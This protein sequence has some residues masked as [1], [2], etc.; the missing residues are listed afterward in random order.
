[1]KRLDTN[2]QLKDMVSVIMPCYN[3]QAF[4]GEAIA[5]VVGQTWDNWELI[6]IDDG[7]QD[8]SVHILQK[9][10]DKDS[11]IVALA[12]EENMGVSKTRNKGINLA[13]GQWIAFLDSD[14]VWK[15]D[16]L[17]RQMLL[18]QEKQ[19][20][21][22][23]TS[24]DIIDQNST[25]LGT[26]ATLPPEVTY[27]ELQCWNR[28][29]CSSVLLSKEALKALR[30]EHDD[31]REDY[32]LWLRILKK[33]EIA[34]SLSEPLVQ[35]RI[36]SGSRSSNKLKMIRDTYRV[37]RHLGTNEVKSVFYTLAHFYCAFFN[38]YRNI[39]D[40]KQN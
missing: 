12:N 29:T 39:R 19:A 40:Q 17:E 24:C 22:I 32:L 25:L 37:H 33:I 13:K 38:K 15:K 6:V 36:I 2:A 26:M 5:S 35:Y 27:A 3:A 18:A 11:R 20:E 7:S 8:E 30:F 4:V 16:K 21:F 31:S 28:I 9:W 1:M 14:D 23:F 10:A 34:Y